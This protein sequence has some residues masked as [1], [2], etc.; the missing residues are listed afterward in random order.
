ML[1]CADAQAADADLASGALACPSCHAGR[2]RPWGYGRERVIRLHGGVRK[3]VRP[4]RGRCGSCG[5]TH[6]LVPSWLV[7]RRAD[8]AGVIARAAVASAL[9]GTGTARLGAQLGV[10]AATVRGWLRRLRAR[11]EPT[12]TEA[13][14]MFGR[15]TAGR[16]APYFE[17]SGSPL[18]DALSAVI[19]C[20][21]AAVAWHGYPA[22]A[23]DALLDRFGLAAAL[24]PAPGS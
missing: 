1:L 20:A 9:H 15:L 11:A 8:S 21:L 13:M 3:R 18:G 22:A 2:L 24:A 6:L 23:L 16:D 4:R 12:W 5:A 17:P 14:A 19:A 7:P 10:P